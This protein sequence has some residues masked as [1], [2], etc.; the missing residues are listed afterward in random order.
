MS[1]VLPTPIVLAGG[2]GAVGTLLADLLRTAGHPVTICDPRA[3]PGPDALR[4][5][6]AQPTAEVDD[7][8][9]VAGTVILAV[10][11]PVALAALPALAAT[12]GE[13][14]LLVD[15][16]SVKTRIAQA[17]QRT[18]ARRA[19]VGINPMYAPAL[20]PAGRPIAVVRYHDGAAV[21]ALVGLLGRHGPIVDVD[22]DTHDRVTA[23][24]Q[25]LTHAVILAF[26]TALDRLDVPTAARPSATPPHTV[27]RA[28]L[29]RLTSGTPAVYHDIQV[30][31]PHAASAR[32]ALA[33]AVADLDTA[34]A[35][36]PDRF[37]ALL[38]RAARALGD[39][40]AF[41]RHRCAELFAQLPPAPGTCAP[42][43]GRTPP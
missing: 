7:L 18:W 4:G 31:N 14:T 25:A 8:L 3:E 11:E 12:A 9:A 35:L 36:G 43:S 38:E 29:A 17:V 30:A 22:A 23:A 33:A 5:D 27:L 34:V 40:A 24:T 2:C 10:P 1:T 37:T 41:D 32:S 26:G 39:D 28:L 15:T 20:G 19:A 6:I 13:A 21:D 16:L 42:A